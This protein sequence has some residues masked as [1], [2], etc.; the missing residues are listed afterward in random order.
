MSFKSRISIWLLKWILSQYE[1]SFYSCIVFLILVSHLS[2]LLYLS[3][4]VIVFNVFIR[5]LLISSSSGSTLGILC[6]Y[7]DIVTLSWYF[8]FFNF[9]YL[10]LLSVHLKAWVIF[11]S[12]CI[13]KK[14]PLVQ[15]NHKFC[16]HGLPGIE[17]LDKVQEPAHH[18]HIGLDAIITDMKSHCMNQ[19]LD[20][21]F[22]SLAWFQCLLRGTWVLVSLELI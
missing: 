16:V 22:V 3:V 17:T 11:F 19:C 5:Y 2:V 18:G 9:C 1:T 12:L 14:M 15:Q 8:S 13:I 4:E 21:G 10:Y 6:D 7:S 20:L